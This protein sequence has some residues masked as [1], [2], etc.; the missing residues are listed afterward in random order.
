MA[1]RLVEELLTNEALHL[2]PEQKARMAVINSRQIAQAR[3]LSA[4]IEAGLYAASQEIMATLTGPQQVT[5]GER[6]HGLGPVCP[7]GA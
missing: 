7:P 1:H 6:H 2:T 5:L 4:Q 3:G